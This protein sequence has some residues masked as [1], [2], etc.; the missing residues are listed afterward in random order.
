MCRRNVCSCCWRVCATHTG[1][2]VRAGGVYVCVV[3]A[4]LVLR[5][6]HNVGIVVLSATR[7]P[8]MIWGSV[9]VCCCEAHT[10]THDK[11]LFTQIKDLVWPEMGHHMGCTRLRMF[12]HKVL[13]R[14][15]NVKELDVPHTHAHTYTNAVAKDDLASHTSRLH[16]LTNLVSQPLHITMAGCSCGV[17]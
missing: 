16:Q 10:T 15:P 7:L 5:W 17:P 9:C 13:G 4:H 6:A 12:A 1:V 2:C 3:L 11:H 8:Y 14:L